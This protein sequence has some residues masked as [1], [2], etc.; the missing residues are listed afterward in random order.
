MDSQTVA[1][2]DTL[3]RR[4]L[5]RLG[6]QSG[7]VTVTEE[8][9]NMGLCD[10]CSWPQEGFAVHVNGELVYPNDETLNSFGGY[11]HA[12]AAGYVNGNQLTSWGAFFHWLDGAN[13]EAIAER[14]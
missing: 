10:T 12:D 6:L 2:D 1:I 3:S 4:I 7:T 11:T 8:S 5:N 9:W 14:Y 13:L